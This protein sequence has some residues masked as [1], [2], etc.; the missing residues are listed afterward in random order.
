M[1][2]QSMAFQSPVHCTL[3]VRVMTLPLDPA[4]LTQVFSQ[5][6]H[7]C[8][9]GGHD[10]PLPGNQMS[11]WAADPVDTLTLNPDDLHVEA[12]LKAAFNRYALD[13]DDLPGGLPP[14]CCG[15]MG[16]FG[17][18]LGAQLEPM[19]GTTCNDLHMPLAHLF[20]YD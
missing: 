10:T 12:S 15:W 5:L 13:R 9:L 16:Y 8:I 20:F 6:D 3:H 11:Y 2:S 18:D 14:F 4:H 7:P 1:S 17:Y 19:P